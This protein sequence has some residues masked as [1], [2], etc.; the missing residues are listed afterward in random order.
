MLAPSVGFLLP[1]SLDQYLFL[2]YKLYGLAGG[3][4]V[5]YFSININLPHVSHCNTFYG[6]GTVCPSVLAIILKD[7]VKIS[8]NILYW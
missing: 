2:F 5:S 6:R 1:F 7:G 4:G 8:W 3:F